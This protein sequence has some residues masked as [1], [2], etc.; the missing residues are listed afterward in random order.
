MYSEQYERQQPVCVYS[1]DKDGI[2]WKHDTDGNGWDS[3]IHMYS[4]CDKFDGDIKEWIYDG[5]YSDSDV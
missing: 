4:E 2:Q 3:G 1:D 5:R